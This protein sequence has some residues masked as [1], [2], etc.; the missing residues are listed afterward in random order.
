MRILGFNESTNTLRLIPDTLDDLYLLAR[1]I[2]SGDAV[3]A[4]TYRRYRPNESDEGEQKEIIV[5]IR[6]EKIEID[7]N[8]S[9]LRLTGKIL[10][11]KPEEY[12][13]L[14]SYHTLNIACG[15]RID[16]TR[17]GWPGYI[18]EMLKEAVD[19]SKRPRLGVIA[20]DDEKAAIAYVRGY[21]IDIAAEI[22]SKLS[23]KMKESEYERQKSKFFDEIISKINAMQVDTLIIAGPGLMK[24]DLKEYIKA[25]RIQISKNIA[26]VSSSD[27]ERSGIKEAIQSEEVSKLLE[28]DKIKQEFNYLNL[29]LRGLSVGASFAG[30]EKVEAAIDTYGAGIVLVNDS[31]INEPEI[32]QLLNKAYE[33][34]AKIVIFNADDDAGMQLKGLGNIAVIGK[35]LAG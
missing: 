16:I 30:K 4:K 11:G 21:G 8:A 32:K 23:K 28:R 24:D 33:Q 27:A 5:K 12:V 7:K 35:Q 14:G 29:L 31:V 6:V 19:A 9:R 20:L 3:E 18:R 13:S 10:S 26:W 25:N 17:D 34:H 22:Y 1:I 2:S 15:E